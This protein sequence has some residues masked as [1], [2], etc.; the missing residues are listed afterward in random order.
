[1]TTKETIKWGMPIAIAL[2]LIV[3]LIIG[4]LPEHKYCYHKFNYRLKDLNITECVKFKVISDD[5]NFL[6][7]SRLT[8]SDKISELPDCEGDHIY[9]AE[10][11]IGMLAL[12]E[13]LDGKMCTG[14]WITYHNFTWEARNKYEEKF[15]GWW[16][17]TIEN[18]HETIINCEND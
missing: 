1:M 7:F 13:N 6:D 16:N 12:N 3:A 9:Y 17:D 14:Y 4:L 10:P 8:C 11:D 5:I 15:M 18:L 2:L